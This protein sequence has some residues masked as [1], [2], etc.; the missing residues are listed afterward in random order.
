M[1]DEV[2]VCILK[3]INVQ[4]LRKRKKSRAH[5]NLERTR[6]EV[7]ETAEKEFIE[8]WIIKKNIDNKNDLYYFKLNKKMD[9]RW[10][11]VQSLGGL[12]L[13]VAL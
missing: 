8:N 6:I 10:E 13:Q 7:Q 2:E 11:Q 1:L 12:A 5:K 4:T 3:K 9:Q